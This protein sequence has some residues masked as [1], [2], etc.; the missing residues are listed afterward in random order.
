[1]LIKVTVLPDMP[2]AVP[3]SDESYSRDV[4][5]R[6]STLVTVNMERGLDYKAKGVCNC[7]PDI[8]RTLFSLSVKN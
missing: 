1:M 5:V 7:L 6:H 8:K 4:V 2:A 3:L